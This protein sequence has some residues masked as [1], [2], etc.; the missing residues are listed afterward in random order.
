MKNFDTAPE[1]ATASAAPL[2]PESR[3]TEFVSV[4][5]GGET[6]SGEV[7]LVTAYVLMWAAVAF[8]IFITWRKQN[9]IDA[10]LKELDSRVRAVQ[11]KV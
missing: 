6:S 7:L 1:A 9:A 2:T 3:S 10:K 8:F 5:G 4:T 11:P